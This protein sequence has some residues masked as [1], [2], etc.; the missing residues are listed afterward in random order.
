MTRKGYVVATVAA[1]LGIAIASIVSITPKLIWNAS[2][3]VPIGLYRVAPAGQLRQS[4]L[5]AVMPPESFG[6]FMVARG[7]IGRDVLIL[8]HVMGLPG[9]CVCRTDGRVTVDDV[10]HGDALQRDSRGR[11][12]PVWQGCR[13]LADDEIFLMNPKVRDSLDSRYFGPFPTSAVIGRAIPILTSTG[14]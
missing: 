9:Q 12:L 13:V 11:A 6:S 5:V 1:V 10:A 2:A 4:D 7:Y 8:K 3:S 14:G